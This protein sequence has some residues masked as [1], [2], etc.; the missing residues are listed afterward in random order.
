MMAGLRALA[1]PA[2][3][4]SGWVDGYGWHASVDNKNYRCRKGEF[5]GRIFKSKEA[6]L[7]RPRKGKAEQLSPRG[8][9]AHT[10]PPRRKVED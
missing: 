1:G 10:P 3:A 5:A 8:N 4:H 6:F 2:E 9:A 7:C